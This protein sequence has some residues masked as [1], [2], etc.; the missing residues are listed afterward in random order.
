MLNNLKFFRV[1]NLGI[2]FLKYMAIEWKDE[3]SLGIKKIDE[4][5]QAIFGIMNKAHKTINERKTDVNF[6]KI[7][8]DLLVIAQKHFSLEERYFKKFNFKFASVHIKEH[9]RFI[10]EV[11][12]LKKMYSQDSIKLCFE[13]A[14]F[15]EDWFLDHILNEDK[16]Y[17]ELFLKN[18]L[19]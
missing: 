18:G 10:I 14:D 4:Q 5:H 19:K 15:L 1:Y 13:L 6:Q 9:K 7:A 2:G 3:Y 17:K 16:K 11:K 12:Q 8:N